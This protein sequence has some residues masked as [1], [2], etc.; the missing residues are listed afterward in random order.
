[1]RR[2]A[3]E[4]ADVSTVP[5]LPGSALPAGLA[6]RVRLDHDWG[7]PQRRSSIAVSVRWSLLA[8]ATLLALVGAGGSLPVIAVGLVLAGLASRTS[9][10]TRLSLLLGEGLVAAAAV[11][12][13]GVP[14][15]PLLVS[16]PASAIGAGLAAG[17]PGA[18][19][20]T[21]LAASVL[22]VGRMV[23]ADSPDVAA[24]SSASAQWTLVALVTSLLAGRISALSEPAGT[25]EQRY[26]EAH[27]LL[28]QLRAV[29]RGL[30]GSLRPD[31]VASPRAGRGRCHVTRPGVL[32]SNSRSTSQGA[33]HGGQQRRDPAC[34]EGPV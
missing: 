30:P 7:R 6:E 21:G 17:C 34:R 13:A 31:A 2:P 22:L 4:T 24:L 1:M 8:L 26:V 18:V 9:G 12:H 14:A 5:H 16:L 19:V 15:L 23:H 20:A 29:T 28:G 10:R 25:T 11:A 32:P 33:P 3:P 27:R